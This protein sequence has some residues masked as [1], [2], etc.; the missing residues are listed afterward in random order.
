MS[1]NLLFDFSSILIDSITQDNIQSPHLVSNV[2]SWLLSQSCCFQVW[3]L[4]CIYSC[5]ESFSNDLWTTYYAQDSLLCSQSFFSSSPSS[6]CVILADLRW[7]GFYF[8]HNEV[9]LWLKCLC[10][11]LKIKSLSL[12]LMGYELFQGK[13]LYLCHVQKQPLIACQ[14]N[15]TSFLDLTESSE[16]VWSSKD[17]SVYTEKRHI[18]IAL[19]T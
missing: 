13:G 8:S 1:S 11:P 6:S 19:D 14:Q 9:H 7:T 3:F 15:D 18:K 5:S 17:L 12:C 16:L 4:P 10:R 2:R